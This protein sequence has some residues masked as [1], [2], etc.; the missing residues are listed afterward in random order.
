MIVIAFDVTKICSKFIEYNFKQQFLQW[1]MK[2]PLD[3]DWNKGGDT[4]TT[5]APSVIINI[6]VIILMK[7]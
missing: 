6:V 1:W 2:D 5:V 7:N 3:F 4:S